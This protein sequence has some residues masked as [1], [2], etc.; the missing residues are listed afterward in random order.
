[1]QYAFQTQHS[2]TLTFEATQKVMAHMY[3]RII[4]V[5]QIVINLIIIQ[6]KA[7]QIRTLAKKVVKEMSSVIH[8]L[9]INLN[10]IGIHMKLTITKIKSLTV[11]LALTSLYGCASTGTNGVVPIGSNQYMIGGLGKFTEF[12]GSSVKARYFQEA[13]IFCAS[14]G[15]EMLPGAS[16]SKDVENGN[17]ASAE[18]QFRC[19]PK[20]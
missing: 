1:M 8:L 19:I 17:Y 7:T 18:V 4:E 5:N 9:T 12:S 2:Q 15:L 6:A 10:H 11:L 3:S 20:N 14:K 16:T 13:A